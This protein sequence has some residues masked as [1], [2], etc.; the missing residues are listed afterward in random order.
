MG[1]DVR[2]FHKLTMQL[3]I[4]LVHKRSSRKIAQKGSIM[5]LFELTEKLS[6][7][8]HVL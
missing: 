3:N 2:P 8:S 4:D 6:N 5:T 1:K 7:I